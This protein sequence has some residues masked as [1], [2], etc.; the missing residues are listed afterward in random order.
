MNRFAIARICEHL[1]S[2]ARAPP[3]IL[4]FS[5]SR[6]FAARPRRSCLRFHKPIQPKNELFD[7]CRVTLL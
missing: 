6:F 3:A 1:V 4:L 2:S 5:V 7:E